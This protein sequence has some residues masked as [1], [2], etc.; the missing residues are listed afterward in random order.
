[1]HEEERLVLVQTG[2]IHFLL[3]ECNLSVLCSSQMKKISM[4]CSVRILNPDKLCFLHLWSEHFVVIVEAH[5][6]HMFI[7]FLAES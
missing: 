7:A 6:E 2:H 4:Q 1:M 5:V 3:S